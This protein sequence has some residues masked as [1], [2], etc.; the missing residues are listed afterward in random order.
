MAGRKKKTQVKKRT[1]GGWIAL[2]VIFA[3]VMA[4]CMVFAYGAINANTVHVRYAE[5]VIRDLPPAFDGC[6]VLFVSD[7]DLCGINS[8]EKAAGFINKLSAVEADMLLLGGD[9][10]STHILDILNQ[11]ENLGNKNK[12]REAF[13]RGIQNLDMPLGKYAVA[14]END[15]DPE[16]LKAILK[17]TGIKPLFNGHASV[18]KDGQQ[19]HIVGFNANTSG[20][21][22]N[23]VA[24]AFS[25]DDCVIAL[26]HSPAAFPQILTAEAKDSGSWADLILAGH[27]HGGQIRLADKNIIKLSPQE[28]TFLYGWKRESDS[29]ILTTSGLGCEAANIRIG[30][31]PEVWVITL[32][33]GLADLP[34]LQ[35]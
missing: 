5:T 32:K 1:R 30:S 29:L 33:D 11:T 19:I 34:D 6:K 18:K 9:Y 3:L 24:N 14:G 35:V 8:P 25:S 27:T 13:F 28:E 23:N 20:V 26:S 22:F 17:E 12:N 10:T 4:L 16:G 15:H 2:K 7:I 31:N 21:N